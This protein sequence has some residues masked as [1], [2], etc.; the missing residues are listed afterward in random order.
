MPKEVE[1]HLNNINNL[2]DCYQ[3]AKDLLTI[4]QNSV[5]N[6]MS[7]LSL[8]Q[9]RSPSPQPRS[10]SPSPISSRPPPE[11]FRPR[12]RSNFTGFKKYPGPNQPQSIMKRQPRI[13]YAQGRGPSRMRPRSLSRPRSDSGN[14]MPPLR[15]F[16]CNMIGHIAR[17]CFTKTRPH[18]HNRQNFPRRFTRNFRGRQ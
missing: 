10:R 15:C 14:R 3:T 7:T 4:V 8:A 12:T 9:S 16:I 2:Q 17:N 1:L 11:R 6:K 18:P 5:T 13:H